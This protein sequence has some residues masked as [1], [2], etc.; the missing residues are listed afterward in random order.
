MVKNVWSGLNHT[1]RARV[2]QWPLLSKRKLCG[3]HK[4]A[5]TPCS[6]AL[7]P[8]I[9]FC[10]GV[11]FPYWLLFLLLFDS[12]PERTSELEDAISVDGQVFAITFFLNYRN[13]TILGAEATKYHF[14]R[15]G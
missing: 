4:L 11:Y 14:N 7:I 9:A 12:V 2:E 6:A 8:I 13:K 15:C 10:P 5:T 1:L 3:M